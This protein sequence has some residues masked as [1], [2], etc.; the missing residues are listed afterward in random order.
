MKMLIGKI[1]NMGTVYLNDKDAS[2]ADDQNQSF[3]VL[4]IFIRIQ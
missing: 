1:H 2:F 3:F 4:S